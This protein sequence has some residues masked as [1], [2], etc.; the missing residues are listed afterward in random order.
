MSSFPQTRASQK[1]QN[2]SFPEKNSVRKQG[3]QIGRILLFTLSF[4]KLQKKSTFWCYFFPSIDYLLSLTKMG[5]A[6]LGA[7]S[8]Q[9]H[10][11]TLFPNL[12]Y[13]HSVK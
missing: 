6:T 1:S 10:L 11:V 8:S 2:L 3:D 13:S 9:T 5:W 7:I 4:L 12:F